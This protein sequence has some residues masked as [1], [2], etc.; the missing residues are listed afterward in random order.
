MVVGLVRPPA[1]ELLHFS[2][3]PS[4]TIFRP[5]VTAT[6]RDTQPFV[7]ALD[8]D[9]APSY[10]FP[11]DCP[12]VLTWASAKTT[13]VDHERFLGA[14]SRVHAIEYAWLDKPLSTVL[15]AYR[16][17]KSEFMPYGTPEPHAYVSRATIRPLSSPQRV[18]SLLEAHAAAGIELRLLP[19]LWPYWTQ[20]MRS[21][22]G[23][24]GIRLRNARA[25]KVTT[26]APFGQ[27]SA[28]HSV[29]L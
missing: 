11:R 1:G 19:N 27:A 13:T 4:I 10:W 12:R 21:T 26:A 14:F 23:F 16:F 9:Q 18:G 25:E 2:E 24:S 22:L 3:D 7:W 6:A 28:G 20:V 8:F 5:H 17:D 29:R 15:Y